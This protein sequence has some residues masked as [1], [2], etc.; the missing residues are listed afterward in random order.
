M[1]TSY[2]FEGEDMES[3]WFVFLNCV[4]KQQKSVF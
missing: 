4:Q 1:Y 2:G 3:V